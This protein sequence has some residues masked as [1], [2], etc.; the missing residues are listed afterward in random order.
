[1]EKEENE[2][3]YEKTN[4]GTEYVLAETVKTQ[5]SNEK[6]KGDDE[7]SNCEACE[8]LKELFIFEVGLV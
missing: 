6:D 3:K 8:N 5:K 4:E 7:E 2:I 1:M